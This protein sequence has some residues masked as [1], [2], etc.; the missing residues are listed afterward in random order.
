[1]GLCLLL[2]SD[3]NL[4]AQKINKDKQDFSNPSIFMGSS[5][6]SFFQMLHKTGDYET[7]L[8]YSSKKTRKK[9]SDKQL[10]EFYTNIQFSYS[11]KLK[12]KKEENEKIILLYQ[13]TINATQKTIQIPVFIENDTCRIWLDNLN[14]EKPFVGM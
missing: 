11:L 9:Y 3:N 2:S 1:M 8:I 7:M 5:F 14:T 4:Q 6:G 12:A 10:V 13:T